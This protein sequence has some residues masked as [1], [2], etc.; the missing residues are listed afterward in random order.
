MIAIASIAGAY[1]TTR[2]GEEPKYYFDDFDLGE[3]AQAL[4]ID[5]A[6]CTPC[7]LKRPWAHSEGRRD[8][9]NSWYYVVE[10]SKNGSCKVRYGVNGELSTY[11]LDYL[12]LSCL[13]PQNLGTLQLASPENNLDASVIKPYC[14]EIVSAIDN[15]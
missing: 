13:V 3:C 12:G 9:T 11:G 1:L 2:I 5:T 10:G 14:Q 6:S 15:S 4:Q 7:K 8:T